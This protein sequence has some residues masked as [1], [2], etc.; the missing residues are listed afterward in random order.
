MKWELSNDTS[1]E[2]PAMLFIH[3]SSKMVD[4]SISD[5]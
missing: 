4:S 1:L 3:K 2:V 5:R